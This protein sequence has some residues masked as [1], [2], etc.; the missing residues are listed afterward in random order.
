VQN[1]AITDPETHPRELDHRESDGIQVW[2]LWSPVT[3]EVWVSVLDE[4]SGESFRV[5][6]DSSRALDAFHHPFAY[7]AA[8]AG[9]VEELLPA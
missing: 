1:V 9:E 2:L 7:L 4:G 5:D 6:V 8:G 3:G